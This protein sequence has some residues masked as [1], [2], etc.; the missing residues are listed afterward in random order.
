MAVAMVVFWGALIALAI[1]AVRS[2]G[3]NRAYQADRKPNRAM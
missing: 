2:L 3:S 1:W